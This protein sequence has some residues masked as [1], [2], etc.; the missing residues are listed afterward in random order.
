MSNPSP[1]DVLLQYCEA[2]QIG[3]EPCLALMA[4][5]IVFHAPCVPAP[6]PKDLQG[7]EAVAGAYRLLFAKF[8]KD[9]KWSGEVFSARED[10]EVAIALMKSDVELMDGRRYAN[11]YTVLVRVR[12]GKIREHYEFFDTARAAEGFAGLLGP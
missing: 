12:D 1:R 8:F 3:A 5:D 6:I 11:D 4:E 7:L 10:D 2:M 9:F